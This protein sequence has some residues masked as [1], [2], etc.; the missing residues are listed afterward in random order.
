MIL[1]ISVVSAVSSLSFRTWAPLLMRL[2]KSLPVLFIF[3]KK[4]QFFKIGLFYF[5]ISTLFK[6]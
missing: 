2:A 3:S 4:Q 6:F 1:F 5:F